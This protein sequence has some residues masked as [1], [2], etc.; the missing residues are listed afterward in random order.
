MAELFLVHDPVNTVGKPRVV[1][2]HG[3]DGDIRSTWMANPKLPSTLWPK[4]VGEDTGCPVWLLGYGAATSRWKADAMALPRQATAVLERLS[5][6][7]TLMQGP[8]ILVGHS[9]GGLVI[10]TAMQHAMSRNV[11]RHKAIVKNVRGIAFVGTPHFGSMLATIAARSHFMRANPQVSDLRLD[12]AHLEALN[13]YFLALREDLGFETRVFMETQPVRLPWWLL[14]RFFPG[15]T[16]VSPASSEAHIPNE[17]SIPIQADHVTICKPKDRDAAIHKS[18]LA[19]VRNVQGSEVPTN[20]KT[21]SPTGVLRSDDFDAIA[22]EHRDSTAVHLAFAMC[23]VNLHGDTEV[24]V[25]TSVCLVT[26]SPDRVRQLLRQI[27]SRIHEDPLIS[28]A[29][30]KTIEAASLRQMVGSAAIRGVLLRE[31]AVI[32]FSAY[33][34]YAKQTPFNRLSVQEKIRMLIVEPLF[35]RLS[36]KS[37]RIVQVHTCVSDIEEYLKAAGNAVLTEYQRHVELPAR[38][39]RRY[40]GLEELASL[41]AYASAHHLSS[42]E[43]GELAN[44]FES[45]RTRIRFA[46]NVVTREKHKRDVNPLP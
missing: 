13:Q 46:E 39:A 38:C 45:L 2:I 34:Y 20:K 6:E 16:I 23:E 41:I 30:K 5:N 29:A 12:D 17:V 14:G 24:P 43:D 26:D 11:D 10:K 28:A 8:L 35:H 33:L 32:S 36:K 21:A 40:S 15:V 37:E 1:F 3:L 44:I 4:W 19:F 9:L 31:L 22:P 42:P 27:G 25:C 18:L 7:S